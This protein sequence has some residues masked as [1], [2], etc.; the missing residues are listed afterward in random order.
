MTNKNTN[1]APHRVPLYR[2]PVIIVG[3]VAVTIIIIIGATILIRSVTGNHD[4]TPDSSDEPVIYQDTPPPKP[5]DT[6]PEGATEPT[7]IPQYEGEDPNKL[8]EL[9][10]N[11]AYRGVDQEAG[12]L[13]VSASIDQ[14]LQSDGECILRLLRDDVE[15]YTTKVP[16]TADVTTSVCG[17]FEVPLSKLSPGTYN[18]EI[19]LSADDKTGVI[20]DEVKI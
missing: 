4:Q 14:Y 8:P 7:G 11:V 5:A 17:S 20:V 15:V 19:T 13:T 18:I 10:G 12:L 1:S 3:L 9:T 6:E 16:A 2:R